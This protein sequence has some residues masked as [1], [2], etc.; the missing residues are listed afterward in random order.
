M[1]G[2]EIHRVFDAELEGKQR[3]M[4][5]LNSLDQFVKGAPKKTSANDNKPV[6]ISIFIIKQTHRAFS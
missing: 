3:E 4:N 6:G 1:R 5:A 2:C